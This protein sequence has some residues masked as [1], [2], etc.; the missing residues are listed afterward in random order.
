MFLDGKGIVFINSTN[1]HLE[2][3]RFSL[4]TLR[5][6]GMGRRNSE[7]PLFQLSSDLCERIDAH[8]IDKKSKPIEFQL[9]IYEFVSSIISFMIFG[10]DIPA[11][12][13]E[14]SQIL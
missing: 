6:F 3:R 2:Q 7:P 13:E 4:N 8:C 10:S 9:M 5:L 11:E 12:D 14:F 1:V